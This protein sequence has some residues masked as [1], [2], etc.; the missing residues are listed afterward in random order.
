MCLA[1]PL[2]QA[3]A[4]PLS[5]E[6]CR[7][8]ALKFNK[9]RQ[10]ATLST[11]AARFTMKSYYAQFFPNL[12]L[13]GFG[14]YDTG[15]G[16][17]NVEGGMLPVGSMATGSFVPSGSFAYF[18]GLNLDYKLGFI[19]SGSVVLKQPLYMGGRIQAAYR[20][21][22][23]AVDLYRQG[24]RMT[25]AEVIQRADEAYARV[26]NARELQQVAEKYQALLLELDKNVESAVRHGLKMENDRMKVQVKLN[27]VELQLRRAQN[28]VRLATMNLCHATGQPLGTPLEVSSQY[29]A[30]DDAQAIQTDDVSARPEI[31]MLD[32]QRQIA[33]QQVRLA[34][35]EMLPQLALLAKYGYTHGVEFNGR[36]LL[37]GWNFAGGVT[38]SI[39]L[40]H[41][42]EHSNK[43]KAA[44]TRLQQ[45]EVELENK[46]ELMLLELNRAANNL[47]EA[48]LE[49]SLAEKTLAQAEN[50]MKL[51]RQQYDAG[52]EP[53]SDYLESQ[54]TWQQAYESLVNAH[55]QRYLSSVAY[56]RSAGMLVQ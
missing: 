36:S 12:S 11:E 2:C 26:V 25:E 55:F 1:L 31:A 41:F 42:G 17:L 23:M 24:E 6:Q 14:I 45:S 27:E 13:A 50:S 21:S 30:V 18:P 51:S 3:Q 53:L 15:D 40:Y 22:R 9:E 32:Y 37:D 20:M 39:P 8:M 4:Q 10:S 29:P 48:R 16:G 38:L 56:L 49:V 28:G 33:G 47:D 46:R 5:I 54:A 44:K 52:L 34:R 35:S 7:Q 19:Y 43:V